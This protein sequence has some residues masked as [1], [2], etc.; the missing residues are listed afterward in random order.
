MNGCRAALTVASAVTKAV[1][2]LSAPP[3]PLPM[4]RRWLQ[5]LIFIAGCGDNLD[6][7]L[8]Y[9]PEVE[10]A[11]VSILYPLPASRDQMISPDEQAAFG[12]LFPEPWFPTAIGPVDVGTSYQDMRLVALRLDP[13][14]ARKSCTPEVRAIFQPVVLGPGGELTVGDGAIHVFYG[15]PEGELVLFLENILALKK[16]HGAGIAYGRALGPHPILVAT[17]LDGEFARGLHALV[18]QH[19]GDARIERFTELNHQVPGRDRWDFYLFERVEADLVRHDIATTGSDEQQVTGTHTDPLLVGGIAS[20]SPTLDSPVVAVVDEARPVAV[21]EAI[22]T[23]F[24]RAVALQ[25]PTKE[26]SESIDCVSC[27]LAEGARHVGATEYGLT[28]TAAFQSERS[29]EY[30]RD[31]RA[32][33]NLHMFAYVGRSVSVSQRV[34][35]ESAVT[36]AAMQQ[37]LTAKNWASPAAP[38]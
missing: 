17:G 38:D 1:A 2:S 12:Q 13:C 5:A 27:H 16:A 34:A 28:T 29:L 36:A 19:L 33:T 23:G 7:G 8:D 35:N 11:D 32:V 15:L 18:L 20:V 25:D 14:S 21:T 9:D 31:I 4:T 22:R 24:A 30:R 26:T 3:Y 37:I 10:A 6:P